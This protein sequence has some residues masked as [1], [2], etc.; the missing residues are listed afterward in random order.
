MYLK[1]N[2]N[3]IS[4][5]PLPV[6]GQVLCAGRHKAVLSQTELILEEI[7][8]QALKNQVVLWCLSF[9]C[10]GYVSSF[11]FYREKPAKQSHL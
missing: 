4:V 1:W 8:P 10:V 2:K 6:L 3:E 11:S 9:S 5:L 7:T